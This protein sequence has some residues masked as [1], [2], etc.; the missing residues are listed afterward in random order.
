MNYQEFIERKTRLVERV[1]FDVDPASLNPRLKPFQRDS[2]MWAVR[3]GRFMGAQ[4]CGL[5]KSFE[6]LESARCVVEKTG[7]KY[8]IVCPL[9]VAHQTKREAEKFQV[10]CD[11]TV[12]QHPEELRAGINIINYERLPHFKNEKFCGLTLDEG[13]IIKSVDGHYRRLLLEHFSH[14]QF[15]QSWSATPA[16]NDFMELGNQAQFC[17]IMTRAEMLSVFFV[18]DGGET[19][20]WRLKKHAH[21]EFWN[22]M[23]SW[24]MFMQKPSDLG[25]DDEGY[26][27]PPLEYHEVE[28]K[29]KANRSGWLFNTEA[30]TLNERRD[31]RKD[32]MDERV[33]IT[34]D[35]INASPD[36]WVVWCNYNDEG[37]KLEKAI[38]DSVQVAGRHSIEQKEDRLDG[39]T[40][41]N[42][43]V[44]IIKPKIGGH[45]L[46][47]Q[48]CHN[49][50]I[51]PTDSWEQWYQMIRRF[52]RFGQQSPVNVT[53]IVSEGESAV[54][55]NLFRKERDAQKMYGGIIASMRERMTGNIK[56]R[57]LSAGTYKPEMQMEVPSWLNA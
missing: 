36:C 14:I 41:G 16:P 50:I 20:K 6:E 33:A 28:I 45:G 19:S 44:L 51:Y 15:R 29:A 27:L 47:W 17:G 13:S 24:S 10:N 40:K 5:G 21:K 46:N 8:L 49:T 48:H 11:V 2:V 23:A 57:Q 34:A 54:V 30:K 35:I 52:Y 38:K 31:A 12:C 18:H 9:A 1:G 37:D 3:Q 43:R 56:L 22:W 55:R 32:S 53:Y 26:L 4:D 7:E 42:I 25:Y 39:F